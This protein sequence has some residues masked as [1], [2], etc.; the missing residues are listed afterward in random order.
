MKE[1]ELIRSAPYCCVCAILESVLKRRGYNISQ[2]DIAN[3][4]GL[5]C[6]PLDKIDIPSQIHNIKISDD[7]KDWGVHLKNNTLNDFFKYY[8]IPLKETFFRGDL[9]DEIKLDYFLDSTSEN[10][11]I[12][13]FISHGSLYNNDN[14]I[15]VGHSI[16]YTGRSGNSI[17]Y[18][19]PGP[20]NF[21]INNRDIYD[22]Y[23][24]IKSRAMLDGGVSIISD[25][26]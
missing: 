2:F 17:Q 5:I 8:N 20:A 14:N 4:I 25:F 23:L 15:D 13:M 22:I 9:F 16:L 6:S 10:Y 24:S 11:D 21:G 7:A 19:D 26:I 12:I 3:Y 18:I 1:Y